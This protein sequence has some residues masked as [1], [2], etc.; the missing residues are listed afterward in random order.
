[1]FGSAV[2]IKVGAGDL[3]AGA[4]FDGPFDM[5]PRADKWQRGGTATPESSSVD[6]TRQ[7]GLAAREQSRTGG[8]GEVAGGVASK[9]HG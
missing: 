9:N 1:M 8:G 5:D 7:C 2:A 4:L 6:P 3:Q